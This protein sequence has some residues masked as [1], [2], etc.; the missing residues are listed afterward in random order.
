MPTPITAT[1]CKPSPMERR[2]Y[3]MPQRRATKAAVPSWKSASRIFHPI[4]ARPGRG[5]EDKDIVMLQCVTIWYR[6]IRPFS[7]SAAVVPVLVGST[8]ATQ[9]GMFDWGLFCLVL[10]G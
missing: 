5:L 10:L 7:L 3:F 8:L 9:Y 1:A 6:A 2:A 4:A